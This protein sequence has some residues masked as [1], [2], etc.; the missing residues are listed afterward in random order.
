MS[1]INHNNLVGEINELK[2][3]MA[4]MR[5]D[6]RHLGDMMTRLQEVL[7]TSTPRREVLEIEARF[8]KRVFVMEASFSNRL[9]PLEMKVDTVI[10]TMQ[11]GNGAM[12]AVNIVWAGA[13]VI[14]GIYMQLR[15]T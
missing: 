6:M 8:E 1:E 4:T 10:A 2:V 14:F 13:L 12:W 11:K 3:E 7:E 9:S 15:I 5:S